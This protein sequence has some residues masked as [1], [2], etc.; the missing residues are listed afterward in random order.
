MT[1]F[2]PL[3]RN[4][5]GLE[6]GFDRMACQCDDCESE[7]NWVTIGA[8]LAPRHG[9]PGPLGSKLNFRFDTA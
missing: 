1:A 3:R 9:N 5:R 6:D 7:W 4:T 8:A 2:A